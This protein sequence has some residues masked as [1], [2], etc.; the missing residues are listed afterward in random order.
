MTKQLLVFSDF[1]EALEKCATSN[2]FSVQNG[3]LITHLANNIFWS[4]VRVV[5]QIVTQYHQYPQVPKQI[6]KQRI[7]LQAER[8]LR[9]QNENADN[10][11]IELFPNSVILRRKLVGLGVSTIVDLVQQ[12]EISE[13]ECIQQSIFGHINRRNETDRLT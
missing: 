12:Q 11:K 1:G 5:E 3:F 4:Q 7:H 2:F 10:S 13:K 6:Q 9:E 8:E